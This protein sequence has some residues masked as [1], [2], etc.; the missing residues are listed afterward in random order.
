ML[1]YWS[2]RSI[3]H[4]SVVSKL[5]WIR[6]CMVSRRIRW[7][8]LLCWCC[9]SCWWSNI[10]LLLLLLLIRSIRWIVGTGKSWRIHWCN[11][12]FPFRLPNWL[13]WNRVRSRMVSCVVCILWNVAGLLNWWYNWLLQHVGSCGCSGLPWHGRVRCAWML[14]IPLAHTYFLLSYQLWVALHIFAFQNTTLFAFLFSYF[15]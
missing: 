13:C 1:W 12:T 9:C 10:L 15:S 3:N 11:A 14:E 7:N 6:I 8:R 4:S 2:N 5:N